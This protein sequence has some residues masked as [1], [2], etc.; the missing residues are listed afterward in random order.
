MVSIKCLCAVAYINICG[1]VRKLKITR[2]LV[3]FEHVKI[4]HTLIGMGS[5]AHA[6]AVPY[7]RKVTWISRKVQ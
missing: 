4:L 7:L 1:I 6:A 5:A 2:C 3:L